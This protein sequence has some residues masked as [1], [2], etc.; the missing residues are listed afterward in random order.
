MSIKDNVH[1]PL[2]KVAVC[3]A[4]YNGSKWIEEQVDSILAQRDVSVT[5][6]I[7]VDKSSDQTEAWV[8]KKASLDSRVCSLS[9][10]QKFGGAA[11]NFF[12]LINEID[13]QA[14]DYI[15]LSD[16]DD[17]WLEDKLIEA[18]NAIKTNECDGYSSNVTAFW[19]SGR[20]KL[21]NKA[22]SQRKWD[23][24]FEAAGPGCTYVL[25]QNLALVLQVCINKNWEHIQKI[26]L[27]DWFI[28]AFAR[29]NGYKWIID[30]E[31]HMLYRQHED[32]QVGV[33]QGIKA[34]GVRIRMFAKS[35]WLNQALLI[36]N[37]IGTI[38]SP[39]FKIQTS[40]KRLDPLLIGV[41]AFECR[42]RFRD[43]I[44]FFFFCFLLSV[45]GE[46]SD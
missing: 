5:V 9:H 11:K 39:F 14:Y 38:R 3:L 36:H 44:A 42:R 46:F 30:K 2:P 6:F 12:R 16:Q 21:I 18:V 4:A 15:S 1:T 8:D 45:V 22:Q 31:P 27:H 13:F 40:L 19:T 35:V 33:N 7:S 24:L 29:G 10:G 23:Y 43:Q 17:I 26:I 20:K 28:Y 41:N 37:I 34:A 25:T 32:N